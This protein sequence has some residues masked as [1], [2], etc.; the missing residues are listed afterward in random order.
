MEVLG[1]MK[2]L[3]DNKLAVIVITLEQLKRY[4]L[5]P[6]NIDSFINYGRSI[7]GVEISARF[8]EVKENEYKV[9]LRSKGSIDASE[10]AHDSGGGGHKNAASFIFR[11]SYEEGLRFIEKIAVRVLS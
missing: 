11:G 10:I 7:K 2:L 8:R 4:R 1:Q 6:D 5:G 9:S 3:V